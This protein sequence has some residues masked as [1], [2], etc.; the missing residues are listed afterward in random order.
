[1]GVIFD[2]KNGMLIDE[3][4]GVVLEENVFSYEAERVHDHEDYLRR[5]HYKTVSH[6]T[7][8]FSVGSVRVS[9][10][11]DRW[12]LH[13]FSFVSS[14]LSELGVPRDL[15]SE[16]MFFLRKFISRMSRL[17]MRVV[18]RVYLAVLVYL[19]LRRR[20]NIS[21]REV[22]EV[23]GVRGKRFLHIA[24]RI[25]EAVPELGGGFDLFSRVIRKI[26]SV[27]SDHEVLSRAESIVSSLRE[28]V[29]SG[30]RVVGS[31][32][33][34]LA[35]AILLRARQE[36]GREAVEREVASRMG[37]TEASVRRV[38]KMLFGE[39]FSEFRGN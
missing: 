19:V 25:V 2:P 38:Y 14:R 34:A 10:D 12:L 23:F 31:S 3:E 16:V 8:D 29:L 30:E 20:T 35:A 7:H 18:K 28:K 22:A 6:M 1:M 21:F 9:G 33:S 32:E 27:E 15:R 39:K 4:T 24:S 17:R 11:D 37:V 13:I 26:Y 36:L 5:W